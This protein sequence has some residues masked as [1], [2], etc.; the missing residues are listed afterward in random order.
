MISAV[1]ERK[2]KSRRHH[3]SDYNI[4]FIRISILDLFI[5]YRSKD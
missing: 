2:K 5:N 4:R 1:K 3:E